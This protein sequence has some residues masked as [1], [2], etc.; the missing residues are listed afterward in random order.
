MVKFTLSVLKEKQSKFTPRKGFLPELATKLKYGPLLIQDWGSRLPRTCPEIIHTLNERGEPVYRPCGRQLLK[1]SDRCVF[2]DPHAWR[3]QAKLMRKEIRKKLELG[4]LNFQRYHFPEIDFLAIKK[5]FRGPVDFSE[6]I[7]HEKVH[8]G[9]IAFLNSASFSRTKFLGNVDFSFAQFLKH[10]WFTDA[11]F[12][13]HAEFATEFGGEAFF[14]GAK[15]SG[16]VSFFAA[17]FSGDADFH[18]TKF[19][20]DAWF[21]AEFSGYAWFNSARFLGQTFFNYTRF[22]GTAE[23][24]SCRFQETV[25]LEGIVMRDIDFR[26]RNAVFEQGL[27]VDENSWSESGFRLRIEESDLALA[28]DSYQAIRRGLE[29]MGHYKVAG[30]LFYREM[31]C[32]KNMVSLGKAIARSDSIRVPKQLRRLIQT[33]TGSSKSLRAIFN[34][35]ALLLEVRVKWSNLADWL[36]MRLFD[37]SC[38]FGE[39][40]KRVFLGCI[41]TVF[42]FT[43][44]YFPIV[45][46]SMNTLERLKTSFL[47]SLDAFAPG[48]FLNIPFTSPGEWLVQIE[49]VLGWFMLSVFLVVFTRKMSRG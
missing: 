8:F 33:V 2:H 10:V 45:G 12:S 1:G 14:A 23:F 37:F 34:K 6:A 22:L 29:N 38:G 30:E 47:L 19:S 21:T 32:R 28:A 16:S 41:L 35:I 43:L 49:T 17:K 42:V 48:K 20:E 18:D 3:T 7:F 4:D 44:L 11:E 46:T 27:S 31:T 24:E 15:F 25:V 39:R 26:F 5:E 36:W 13:G 40:P 9:H